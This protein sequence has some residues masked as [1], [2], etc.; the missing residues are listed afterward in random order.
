METIF[1]TKIKQG[2][3]YDQYDNE[4]AY[5]VNGFCVATL[6][7]NSDE[8]NSHEDMTESDKDFYYAEMSKEKESFEQFK[9]YE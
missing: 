2:A 8:F 9:K 4:S 6:N 5:Y 7:H 3:D 1:K